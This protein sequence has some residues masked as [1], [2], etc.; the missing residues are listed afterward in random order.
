MNLT[1]A[2]RVIIYDPDWNPSTDTQVRQMPQPP[3]FIRHN[4]FISLVPLLFLALGAR[5]RVEDRSET[6]SDHL[7]ITDCRDH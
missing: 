2:N 7:Q 3:S 1:G 6:A 5:A 4:L